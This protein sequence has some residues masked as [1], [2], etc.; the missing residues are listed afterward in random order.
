MESHG[1]RRV[2]PS[3]PRSTSFSALIRQ[4]HSNTVQNADY[5][6]GDRLRIV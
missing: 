5:P 4:G 1:F 3:Q 2:V 6:R